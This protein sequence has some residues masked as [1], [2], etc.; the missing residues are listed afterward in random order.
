MPVQGLLRSRGGNHLTA[1]CSL[2]HAEA[3]LLGKE[4]GLLGPEPLRPA[5]AP[6]RQAHLGPGP[7][8]THPPPA[9]HR[10]PP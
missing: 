10:G 6:L 7:G 5:F 8:Q 9:H 4:H 3:H 2:P 1:R